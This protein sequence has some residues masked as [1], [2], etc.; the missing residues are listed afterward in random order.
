MKK[1]FGGFMYQA[2]N[3][4][5]NQFKLFP[6]HYPPLKDYLT[7]AFASTTSESTARKQWWRAEF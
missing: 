1:I 2:K 5:K 4:F 6:K 7:T 3:F